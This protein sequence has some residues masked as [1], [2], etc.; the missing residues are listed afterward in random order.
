MAQVDS[1][2]EKL[3]ISATNGKCLSSFIFNRIKN[4][5]YYFITSTDITKLAE[6][7][8][9][10]FRNGI[11]NGI[12]LIREGDSVRICDNFTTIGSFS[13]KEAEEH[14]PR[15]DSVIPKDFNNKF[16][17]NRTKLANAIKDEDY[18]TLKFVDSKLYVYS[19]KY[20]ERARKV[21]LAKKSKESITLKCLTNTIRESVTFDAKIL[22][23][24]LCIPCDKFVLG[25]NSVVSSVGIY[26]DD[27]N[28]SVRNLI[29]PL[30]IE[31]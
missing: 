7:D 3:R 4:S 8:K 23:A 30:R 19:S 29:M 11:I 31:E 26:Y 13:N 14:Y 17:I 21:I 1:F 28:L 6:C 16:I 20:K 24:I 2:N 15:V 25:F 27:E 5:K 22:K 10:H 12:R 9:F 18:V